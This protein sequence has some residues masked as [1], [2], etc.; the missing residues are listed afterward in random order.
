MFHIFLLTCAL[1]DI[2]K[3]RETLV[4]EKVEKPQ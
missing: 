2:T 4:R 1:R 3:E